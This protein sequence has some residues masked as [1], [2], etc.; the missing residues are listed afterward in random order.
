MKKLLVLFSFLVFAFAVKAQKVYFIYLQTENSTP[1]YLKMGEKIH[2]SA[3]S[4]Y[5][6][7]P[8]LRDSVYNFS[9]GFPNKAGEHRFTVKIS[10]ND[11]GFLLKNFNSG[12]GLFDLQSLEILQPLATIKE[13]E[14]NTAELFANAD[15]FT[16]LLSLAADDPYILIPSGPNP[17]TIAQGEGAKKE[18]PAANQATTA[19][20]LTSDTNTIAPAVTQVKNQEEESVMKTDTASVKSLTGQT[21]QVAVL[22]TESNQVS[23]IQADAPFVRSVITKKSESST[24]EG[25]GLVYLDNLQGSTD[26]IRLLIPN[27]KV[28][29]RI[30][31]Q[32]VQKENPP[33]PGET[34]EAKPAEQKSIACAS[35]ATEK[36]FLKL[37]RSMAS[38]E[39]DDAMIETAVKYF[40]NKCF[41]TEQVK[42]LSTLFLTPSGKYG[43]FDAAYA[44]ISDRDQFIS[45]QSEIKDEYYA[46]RFKALVD[47]TA[48]KSQ[49]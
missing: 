27:P 13:P 24:M 39:S 43:F 7:I 23:D 45:L 17:N 48:V 6:I 15:P 18:Q 37:R 38:E 12:L 46:G 49:K 36:D 11:R 41:S 42:N 19:V 44:H 31:E 26:T 29:A 8:N 1:F 21:E 47:A 22:T 33:L 30:V 14:L 28:V 5:L 34:E 16:R 20:L 4:G 2:S 25:F 32:P 40:R 3:A 10:K 35:L 9:V